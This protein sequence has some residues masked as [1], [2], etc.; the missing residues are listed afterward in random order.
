MKFFLA[1]L[2]VVGV[3]LSH[4]KLYERCELAAELLN[5]HG[6][7]RSQ[8]GDCKYTLEYVLKAPIY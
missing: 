5:V 2:L 6:C 1:M 3:S 4:A 8:L 7:P